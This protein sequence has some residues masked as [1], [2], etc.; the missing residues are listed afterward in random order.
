MLSIGTFLRLFI[1]GR[2]AVR[3]EYA[4]L[5]HRRPSISP[6]YFRSPANL[7]APLGKS[8]ENTRF[9]PDGVPLWSQ[10]LRPIVCPERGE[11]EQKYDQTMQG[12]LA[13]ERARRRVQQHEK[14]SK[15]VVMQARAEE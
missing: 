15:K 1:L 11:A 14:Y 2:Q 5:G 7:G 4:S 3:Y 12:S 6:S 10:P 9:A 8:L 13:C